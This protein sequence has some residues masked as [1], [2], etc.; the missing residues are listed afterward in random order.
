MPS[1]G[2]GN[3]TSAKHP[4]TFDDQ[5]VNDLTA[6]L[7][8]LTENEIYEMLVDISDQRKRWVLLSHISS[9]KHASESA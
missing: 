2:N 4:L 8:E 6:L 5:T 7:E 1:D 9:Y 3:G